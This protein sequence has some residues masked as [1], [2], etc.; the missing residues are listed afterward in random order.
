MRDP[1]ALEVELS[2]APRSRWAASLSVSRSR[3]TRRC[4]ST[5]Q[6]SST[7]PRASAALQVAGQAAVGPAAPQRLPDGQV[8]RRRPGLVDGQQRRPAS[9]AASAVRRSR[10]PGRR[11][12]RRTAAP[13]SALPRP[14]VR[15]RSNAAFELA[16]AAL[17][18]A[19]ADTRPSRCMKLRRQA[20]QLLGLL[21][22]RGL[23]DQVLSQSVPLVAQH[24][25]DPDLAEERLVGPQVD[26]VVVRPLGVGHEQVA[27]VADGEE[28]GGVRR[29]AR[30][31]W[32]RAGWPRP[33]G[34]KWLGGAVWPTLPPA[35]ALMSETVNARPLIRRLHDGV[36]AVGDRLE[37]AAQLLR[38]MLGAA[39]GGLGVQVRLELA[40][41]GH[42]ADQMQRLALQVPRLGR[43]LGEDV[44]HVA[45]G[46]AALV[47]GLV[48][49]GDDLG[50]AVGRRR[51][52]GPRR[53]SPAPGRR[54]S[55]R[56]VRRGRSRTRP[57]PG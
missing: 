18:R 31:P 17:L 43:V 36:G 46:D 2:V 49:V 51:A 56:P 55:R 6:I 35:S 1:D 41:R 7:T 57:R 25:G 47:V 5:S 21:A 27:V 45:F 24:L 3:K 26:G 11:R 42:V 30:P 37:A 38:D 12:C 48:G 53:R 8:E 40:M 33:P 20:G 14:P 32:P 19:R 23:A 15:Q 29:S 39:D 10:G 44:H 52:C 28:R 13:A 9:A 22:G 4:R 16:V 34:R 54:G 50:N